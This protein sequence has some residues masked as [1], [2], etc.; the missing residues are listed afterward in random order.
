MTPTIIAAGLVGGISSPVIL[1]WLVEGMGER[2]FF[3][4]VAGVTV[5][6][7]AAALVLLRRYNAEALRG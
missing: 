7:A 1:S 6:T 5:A 3:Q 4:I 2:G